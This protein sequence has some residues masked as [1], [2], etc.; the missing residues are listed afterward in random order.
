[1]LCCSFNTVV[2]SLDFPTALLFRT[3]ARGE[4]KGGGG[5]EG[6]SIPLRALMLLKKFH[7]SHNILINTFSNGFFSLI[8]HESTIPLICLFFLFFCLKPGMT[9]KSLLQ[10][11]INI[12]YRSFKNKWNVHERHISYTNIVL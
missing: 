1:M 5:G 9:Q 10:T 4:R 11:K 8:I 12:K 3:I 2:C 7:L 6:A